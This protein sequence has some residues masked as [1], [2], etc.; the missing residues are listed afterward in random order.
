MKKKM[1]DISDNKFHISLFTLLGILCAAL[2]TAGGI[3]IPKLLLRQKINAKLAVIEI[4]PESYY[5]SLDTAMAKNASQ[6]LSSMDRM[7]LITG[8]WESSCEQTEQEEASLKESDAVSLA[9][10]QLEHYYKEGIYPYSLSSSYSNWYSW[11][12]EL[13][14]Y[15]DNVFNTYTTY[16][17]VIHF[18]RYDSD[19]V[20]TILMT[21]NGTILAADVNDNSKPFSSIK[22]AYSENGIK[23]I[24]TNEN[25]HLEDISQSTDITTI[26]G[27]P[28]IDTTGIYYKNIYTVSLAL[29]RNEPEDYYIYQYRTDTSYGFGIIPK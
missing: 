12:S 18:T 27:Y 11:S 4:A 19:L 20:H 5:L 15:T 1:S 13:Y 24:F 28:Y 7:K 10:T 21:D 17:W 2:A 29:D 16:L 25:I 8:R 3:F 22:N 14:R 9:R 26:E 6:H 23:Q